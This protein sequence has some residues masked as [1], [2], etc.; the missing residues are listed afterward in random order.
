[1]PSNRAFASFRK[2]IKGVKRN[3]EEKS[4]LRPDGR[5]LRLEPLVGRRTRFVKSDTNACAPV[6]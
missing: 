2:R 6:V 5:A 1:M 3:V 4:T